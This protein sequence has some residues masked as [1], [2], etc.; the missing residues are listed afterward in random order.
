MY[1]SE[2]LSYFMQHTKIKNTFVIDK[3]IIYIYSVSFFRRFAVISLH[4][5]IMANIA[6]NL[7]VLYNIV[8]SYKYL[9]Q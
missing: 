1:E 9:C 6:R 2:I 3:Y 4:N 5:P 8:Y 7:E